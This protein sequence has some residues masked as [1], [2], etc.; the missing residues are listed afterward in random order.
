LK[1]T[2]TDIFNVLLKPIDGDSISTYFTGVL[3]FGT[4]NS[5][6]IKNH[7]NGMPVV[8]RFDGD[9]QRNF[10][11][12]MTGDK[13]QVIITTYASHR[14]G[15]TLLKG[16]DV[17]SSS[18]SSSSVVAL[19]SSYYQEDSDAAD[20]FVSI[21]PASGDAESDLMLQLTSNTSTY[22]SFVIRSLHYDNSMK[23]NPLA[24]SITL[25]DGSP[26][27]DRVMEL[28]ENY[29]VFYVPPGMSDDITISVDS[30]MV[31]LL[32]AP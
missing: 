9:A 10:V 21:V 11:A 22:F 29:Y 4:L 2:K 24:S 32:Y 28:H 1:H 8:M 3:S 17:S 26:Q 20:G 19:P 5:I 7:R 12:P 14:P 15:I 30:V 6:N 27:V 16:T 13:I 18:S 23:V 31:C 25:L